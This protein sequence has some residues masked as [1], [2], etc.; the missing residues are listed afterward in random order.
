MIDQKKANYKL[1]IDIYKPFAYSNFTN[2]LTELIN[3]NLD[4]SFTSIILLCIGTDRATGDSLGPLVGYK[5]STMNINYMHVLGTLEQPVHAKNLT[6]QINDIY[7]THMNPFIIAIDAC[8]GRY[9]HIGIVTVCEGP[10]KPGS[11]VNKDL[12]AVGDIHITGIVN[13]SGFMELLTLQ[14]TRLS[15]VMK[16]ADIISTGIRFVAWKQNLNKNNLKPLSIS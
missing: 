4:S 1:D 14:C 7:K 16:M 2:A 12:P 13:S 11:G 10:L 5:L 15:I 6:D 9:D 3:R 8:L